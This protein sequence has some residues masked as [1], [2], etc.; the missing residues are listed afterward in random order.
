L[1]K[2][3]HRHRKV[4]VQEDARFEDSPRDMI[5]RIFDSS[6]EGLMKYGD[7]AAFWTYTWLF[8]AYDTDNNSLVDDINIMEGT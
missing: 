4:P 2:S 1:K 5:Y 8:F 6:Q 3:A 7:F